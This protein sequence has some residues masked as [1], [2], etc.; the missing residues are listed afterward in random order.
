MAQE[1]NPV[2]LAFSRGKD[3]IA[4]W[5]A[6]REYGIE[7][8]P[9]HLYSIPGLKFVDES[10]KAFED[11]FDTKII[12]LPHPSLYRWLTS[13]VFTPP[14]RWPIIQA[15]GITE[16]T[17]E[18]V[19]DGIR[20]DYDLAGAWNI[21][22]VRAAD[23]PMRRMAMSTHGPVREHTRKMSVIW[24]W[25]IADIRQCLKR[26]AVQLP[27]DYEWFGRSFDGIDY[28][29]L[30]PVRS[31]APDDYARIVSWFPLVELEFFRRDLTR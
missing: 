19:A 27:I 14:E 15:S 28:R 20:A 31:N 3:S 6:L 2:L 9:Y 25:Q 10:L 22:G 5:L 8:V 7:V 24:D 18:E 13:Y 12:D 17:Y 21:D 26:H 11:F 23:S 29:F 4:A 1:G 16:P 30:E